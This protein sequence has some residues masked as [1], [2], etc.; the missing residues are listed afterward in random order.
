MSDHYGWLNLE[1][2]NVR[3]LLLV[4]C[5]IYECQTITVGQ[6]WNMN[7][8]WNMNVRPLLLAKCGMYETITAG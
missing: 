2:M 3:P 1:C 5:G 4:K 8:E 7:V 6:M